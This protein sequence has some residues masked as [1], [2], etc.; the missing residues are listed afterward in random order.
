MIQFEASILSADLVNLEDQVRA[1]VDAGIDGI[2]IDVM[3]GRFVPPITFGDNIVRAIRR[4]TD[5]LLDVHLMIV[6]PEKQIEAFVEAGANRIFVHQEA[7]LHL[8]RTLQNFKKSGVEAGV[9]I[10]P[11]TPWTV[12]EEVLD[13][14]DIVQVMTVNP[15]WGGQAFIKSQLQKIRKLK[16][17]FKEKQLDIPI[18]VDGGV[19]PMT[20]PLVAEAGATVLIAGSSIY[21]KKSPVDVNIVALRKSVQ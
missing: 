15:G 12:L 7:C 14:T 19:D 1:V 16:S 17:I 11:A 5:T 2:Q 13:I 6:E 3:D 8:H 21:N 10:N 20:A 4:V 9:S 18:A